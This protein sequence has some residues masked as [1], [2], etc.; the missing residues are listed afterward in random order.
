MIN[1]LRYIFLILS[2]SY[3]ISTINIIFFSN[4][5]IFDF[6]GL[7]ISKTIEVLRLIVSATI[8]FLLFLKTKHK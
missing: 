5:Q 7:E 2:V 4:K 6:F 1:K 3:I 8:F